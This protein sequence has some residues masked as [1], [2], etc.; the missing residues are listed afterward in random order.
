MRA[1]GF[2]VGQLP[3]PLFHPKQ[4]RRVV[5]FLKGLK[6]LK[7]IHPNPKAKATMLFFED[8]NDAK[9]A[10]NEFIATGN[11]AGRYIMECETDEDWTEVKVLGPEEIRVA[12]TPHPSA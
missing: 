2:A 7:G 6:G 9:R 4:A 8:L 12:G 5:E 3:H 11:A 1:Y 10:R